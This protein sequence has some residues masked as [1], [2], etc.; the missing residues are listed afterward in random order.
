MAD[1]NSV[2]EAKLAAKNNAIWC[3]AVCRSHGITGTFAA[4][5]WTS[6]RRSPRLYPREI[7]SFASMVT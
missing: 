1:P 4:D 6:D 7:S 5:A 3:H 2:V